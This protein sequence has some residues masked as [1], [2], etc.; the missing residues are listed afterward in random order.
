MVQ[1]SKRWGVLALG[2][3]VAGAATLVAQQRPN[4]S[5]MDN[6]QAREITQLIEQGQIGLH[7]AIRLVETKSNGKALECFTM[8]EM[9]SPTAVP[10]GAGK[11][12]QPDTADRP[13]Q[14]G[15]ADRPGQPGTADKTPGAMAGKTGTDTQ[16]LVYHVRVFANGNLTPYMVDAK[17]REVTEIGDRFKQTSDRPILDRTKDLDKNKDKDIDKD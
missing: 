4:F 11:T 14:P 1:S 10:M 13:G 15:A 8:L 12:G 17:T 3:V 7:E 5:T 2:V 9:G 6:N 16:R